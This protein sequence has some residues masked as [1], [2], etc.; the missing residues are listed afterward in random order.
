MMS[1][2]EYAE[3]VNRSVEEIVK[4]CEKLGITKTN[5]DDLLDQDEITMLDSELANVE[6]ESSEEIEHESTT[7][8][9]YEEDD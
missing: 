1:V 8:E 5:E 9:S 6:I 4:L 3:D 7:E 2:L